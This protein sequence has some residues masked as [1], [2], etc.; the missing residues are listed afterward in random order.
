MLSAALTLLLSAEPAACAGELFRIERSKNANVV[1]YE[2]SADAAE[3]VTASWL[4]LAR[5]GE[6][7]RLSFF[8]RL[9][10]YGFEVEPAKGGLPAVLRLKALEA[11]A[12]RLVRRGACLVAVGVIDGAEAVLQRVY[13]TTDED[14]AVPAVRSIELFGVDVATG[15]P[16]VEKLVR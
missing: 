1:V 7:E 16:R 6:R 9:V 12:L 15:A 2:A 11:R 10:A 8:E 5:H 14:G 13:V 3:P 4:L